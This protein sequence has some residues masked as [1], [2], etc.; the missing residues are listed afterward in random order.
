MPSHPLLATLKKGLSV[1]KDTIKKRRDGLLER[2]KNNDKLTVDE[3]TW[4][5]QDANLVEED[6]VIDK[7]ENAS[8][9]ERGFSHLNSKELGLIET[10]NGLA[11]GL[12]QKVSAMVGNK[13]KSAFLCCLLWHP[14][15]MDSG[16][17]ER[18]KPEK[19]D[20]TPAAPIFT[21]KENATLAQRIE[22][23]NWHHA[24]QKPSQSKTAKH[25]DAIYPNLRLKQPLLSAWLK[26][27]DMWRGRWADAE[28]HGRAGGAKHFK[29][30]EHPEVDDM[31]AL[32]IAKAMTQRVHLSGEII[33]EKWRRFADLVGVA[34]ED[35]LTLSDGWLAALKKRCRLKEFKCHGEA[36]SAN[37]ADIEADRKRIQEIIFHERYA[38]RDV[39]NMDETGLFWA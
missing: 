31:L 15:L 28:E 33:Q 29:Q 10:L 5:D 19:K 25:F 27:E 26:E 22:I 39:F 21:K 12:D 37:P 1:L 6:A 24:Q 35:R 36:D 8:D 11:E 3:D 23:L 34:E 4:L 9:Y 32:W 14:R 18:K 7:P 2:L 38:L 17:A 16:P 30:V 13:R 20:K